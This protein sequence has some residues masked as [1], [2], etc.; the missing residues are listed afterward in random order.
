MFNL[1]TEPLIRYQHSETGNVEASLPE[2]YATL[3][4]NEV[5]SFPALRPHQRHA[6]HAFLSQLGAMATHHAGLEEPT[7]DADEWRRIV[8]ALT[9]D[10]PDDEPWQL[11]VDDINQ[12]AFMQPPARSADKL[13]DYKN[14]VDTP[15]EL[16]MPGH[17]Q[18]PTT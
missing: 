7:E 17:F 5:E 13:A 8:R 15:D 6:F 11:V 9:P 12:P 14:R 3:M 16:D 18:K 2:V 1:L 10:F 4:V